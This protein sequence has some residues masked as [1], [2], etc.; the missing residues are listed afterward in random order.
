[1]AVTDPYK[2]MGRVYDRL[3]EPTESKVRG[4]TLD[5]FRPEPGQAV[6][7][8]GC[9]TGTQLVFYQRAGCK[10]SGVDASPTMFAAARKKLGDEADL[11]LE[12]ATRTSFSDDAF[13]LVMVMFV[14][15]EMLPEIRPLVLEECRRIVKRDGSILVADYHNGPCPLPMGLV[16]RSLIVAMEI[17]GGR[18]HFANFRDFMAHD[19][20]P[21]L[22]EA[23]HLSITE[24]WISNEGVAGVFLLKK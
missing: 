22:F 16:W 20:L 5:M 12:S 4:I 13:D 3:I 19:A 18:E 21:P 23:E 24:R 8:I 11:R 17:F 10:V 1:M 6:V 7:D 2:L 14:L 15:H 9:G